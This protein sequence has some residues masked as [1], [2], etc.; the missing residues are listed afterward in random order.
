VWS[1]P[2]T[3]RS[4]CVQRHRC[5]SAMPIAS[6][7]SALSTLFIGILPIPCSRPAMKYSSSFAGSTFRFFAI[8]F[9]VTPTPSEWRQNACGIERPKV[10]LVAER[11]D[12][13]GA[14][15]QVLHG[16]D[17]EHDDRA[18]QRVDLRA[19]AVVRRVDELQ[20]ARHQDRIEA[21]DACSGRPERSPDCSRFRRPC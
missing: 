3:L 15:R 20:H 9:A 12:D 6:T 21:D 18:Y 14:Q 10:P 16:V 8:S 7:Y 17:P 11:V 5:R 19:D 1:N 4:A 2:N 13:R